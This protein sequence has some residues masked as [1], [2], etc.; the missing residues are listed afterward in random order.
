MLEYPLQLF[1]LFVKIVGCDLSQRLSCV[2]RPIRNPV[3]SASMSQL[4]PTSPLPSM[5]QIQLLSQIPLSQIPSMSQSSTFPL[6]PVSTH[7]PRLEAPPTPKSSDAHVNR[8][9]GLNFSDVISIG[10]SPLSRCLSCSTP[11]LALTHEASAPIIS[12]ALFI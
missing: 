11:L 1:V 3:L 8:P 7:L 6:S 2:H 4:P 9:L 12:K 10:L 5:S